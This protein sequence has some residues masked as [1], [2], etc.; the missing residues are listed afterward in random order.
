[1]NIKINKNIKAKTIL[2]IVILVLVVVGYFIYKAFFISEEVILST[3][4][5]SYVNATK[6][7]RLVDTL[8][9]ENVVFNTNLNN[10]MINETQDFTIQINPSNRVGRSNPFLP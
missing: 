10:R 6:L 9:K 1:M 3:A 7:G 8:N 2:P 5:D 4:G